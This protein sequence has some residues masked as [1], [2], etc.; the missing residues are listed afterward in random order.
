MWKQI[1]ICALLTGGVR[2]ADF[3]ACPARIDLQPQQMA[4]VVAGWTASET[5]ESRHELWYV[6][7]YDGEPKEKASLVPDVTERLRTV[8]KLEPAR[9]AYWMECHYT[10]TSI[11][12]ARALPATAKSCEV[13]FAPSVSLDGHPVIRQILCR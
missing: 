5:G 8:W 9:R 10:Q 7:L 2:A 13:T 3:A 11:V 4:K 1:A 12:L 6:T